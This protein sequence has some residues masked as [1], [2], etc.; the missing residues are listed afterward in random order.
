MID[1]IVFVFIAACLFFAWGI[2]ELLQ[3]HTPMLLAT[4]DRTD[5]GMVRLELG[6]E[7]IEITPELARQLVSNQR[8]RDEIRW[9]SM[10]GAEKECDQ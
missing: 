6:P 8:L 10:P 9:A 1:A 5:D 7:R 4:A 2:W 3:D